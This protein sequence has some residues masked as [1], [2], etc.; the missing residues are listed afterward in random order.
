LIESEAIQQVQATTSFQLRKHLMIY[1]TQADKR[2]LSRR[3]KKKSRTQRFILVHPSSRAMSSPL[4]TSKDF[5]NKDHK[6]GLQP[7]LPPSYHCSLQYT[8]LPAALT[9]H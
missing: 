7:L 1:T 9:P 2:N 6:I 8:L 4:Q 3:E 5:H